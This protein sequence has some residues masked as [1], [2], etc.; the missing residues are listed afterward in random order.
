M[1]L[2]GSDGGVRL[3]LEMLPEPLGL[4]CVAWPHGADGWLNDDSILRKVMYFELRKRS[5]Q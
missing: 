4:E 2:E 1:P 3:C 5:R